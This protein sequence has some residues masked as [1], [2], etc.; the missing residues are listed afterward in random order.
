ML[1]HRDVG[2]TRRYAV[3]GDKA[4]VYVLRPDGERQ[5]GRRFVPGPIPMRKI[6]MKPVS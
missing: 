1:G 5:R 2:S 6:P 4:L 3:L